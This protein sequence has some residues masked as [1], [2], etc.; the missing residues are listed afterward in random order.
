[1][2]AAGDGRLMDDQATNRNSRFIAVKT[3]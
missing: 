3:R 2:L 1:M